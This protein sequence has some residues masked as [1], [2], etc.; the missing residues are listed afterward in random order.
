MTMPDNPTGRLSPT[1]LALWVLLALFVLR[2]VGQILVE[3]GHVGWLPP[4]PEWFSGAIPYPQLL[5]SQFVVIAVMAAVNVAFTLG[6]RGPT[7][8]GDWPVRCCWRS[9]GC[10]SPSW[11]SATS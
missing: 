4:S 3:F 8:R 2:V 1:A 6:P 5:A 11:S 9:A 10:T 7:G